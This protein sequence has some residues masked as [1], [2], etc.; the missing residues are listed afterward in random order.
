M[1]LNFKRKSNMEFTLIGYK[2]I[3]FSGNLSIIKF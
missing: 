1:Y 3:L 2:E